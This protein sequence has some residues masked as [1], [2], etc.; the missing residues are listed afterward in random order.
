MGYEPKYGYAAW[1]NGREDESNEGFKNVVIR[2]GKYNVLIM[3]HA[4]TSSLRRVDETRH[5]I[6][7]VVTDAKTNRI[8]AEI[9]HKGYFGFLGVRKAGKPGFFMALTEKD[10][11][12]EKETFKSPRHRSINV[13]NKNKLDKRFLYRHP[14]HTLMLGVYE[15]WTTG[16]I[17][18][19]SNRQGILRMDITK[20][21]TGIPTMARKK[22]KVLL[23]EFESGVF[24]RSTGVARLMLANN[25]LVGRDYCYEKFDKLPRR[26]GYFYTNAWGT[27]LMSGP[28]RDAIRQYVRPGFS[29]RLNGEFKALDSWLGLYDTGVYN[30]MEDHG[31]GLNPDKN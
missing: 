28:G 8:Q 26:S 24:Y 13:L 3:F 11:K 14:K 7:F 16:P 18:A 1:K 31:Y 5:T 15:D 4:Q 22:E 29:M 19:P 23:G 17:C 20:S 10:R 2:N 6:L 27:K 30:E 25:F 21:A 9:T 12:I